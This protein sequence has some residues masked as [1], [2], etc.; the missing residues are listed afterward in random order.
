MLAAIEAWDH[1]APRLHETFERLNAGRCA[2]AFAYRAEDAMAAL[3]RSWQ[4]LD[5]SAF[6]SHNEILSDAWGYERRSKEAPPLMYQGLSDRFHGPLEEV[7]FRS[8]EDLIDF[9]AEYA[10]VVDAVPLGVSAQEALGHVKLVTIINDWSLRAFGPA[11]MKG[12]F[13]FIHAKPPSAMAGIAVTPDALGAAWAEGRVGLAMHVHRDGV[14]FGRP[15]GREMS[16]GF[17]DLIAHAAATRDLCAGTIIGSGTVSNADAQ[18]AGSGCIAERVALERLH[19][20]QPPTGYLQFGERVRLEVFD[21]QGASVFGP[22][23]QQIVQR[24]VKG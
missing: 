2:E 9:E 3:P 1:A 10:V 24:G 15:H 14:E 4:F 11:E 17:G 22:I 12:G 23:D 13:G 8:T 7:P 5:A 16:F 6:L 21:A 20:V 18:A 19:P